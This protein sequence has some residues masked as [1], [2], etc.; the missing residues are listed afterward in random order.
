MKTFSLNEINTALGKTPKSIE[1]MLFS[2]SLS[3]ILGTI[4]KKYSLTTDTGTDIAAAIFYYLTKL[5]SDQELVNVIGSSV[6]QKHFAAFMNDLESMLWSPF[7]VYLSKGDIIYKQLTRFEPQPIKE[8]AP[9]PKQAQQTQPRM[10]AV[11]TTTPMPLVTPP[12]QPVQGQP[13]TS[14]PSI[15]P[16][17]PIPG[18]VPSASQPPKPAPPSTPPELIVIGESPKPAA[19]PIKPTPPPTFVPTQSPRIKVGDSKISQQTP[20]VNIPKPP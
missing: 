12:A 3:N 10:D 9:Q 17:E 14:T 4:V 1:E 8:Q 20:A 11:K 13:S 7:D 6:P 5:I 2:P 18:H 19:A 16:N 15:K